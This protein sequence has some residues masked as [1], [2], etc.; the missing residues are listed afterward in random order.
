MEIVKALILGLVQGLTEFLP[1]S[2]SG[3][4][5]IMQHYLNFPLPPLFFDII[6][7]LG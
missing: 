5:V 7:H 6:L 4:L 2:S 1:V 3:H